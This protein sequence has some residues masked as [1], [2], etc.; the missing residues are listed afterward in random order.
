R[1]ALYH[2]DGEAVD[3]GV[4]HGD[5]AAALGVDIGPGE[6]ADLQRRIAGQRN[7]HLAELAGAIDLR[8]YQADA[9]DEVRCAVAADAGGRAGIEFQ[10]MDARHLGIELDLVVDRDTEHWTSL[11][12][13]RRADDGADLG[14]QTR[15]GRPERDRPGPAALLLLALL[16]LALLLLALL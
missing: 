11:R 6:H 8:R 3:R 9:A 13:R 2:L 15:C 12:R 4:G 5:A 16:L 14:D 7:A 10:E 1:V